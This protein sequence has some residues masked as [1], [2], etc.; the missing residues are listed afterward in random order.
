[1]RQFIFK[2]G[3]ES[4]RVN[5]LALLSRNRELNAAQGLH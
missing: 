2:H 3:K 1:M 5:M 4:W